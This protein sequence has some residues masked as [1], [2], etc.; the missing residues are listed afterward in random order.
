VLGKRVALRFDPAPFR[1]SSS[2]GS[3]PAQKPVTRLA[4]SIFA[5]GDG[6]SLLHQRSNLS[7]SY[8]NLLIIYLNITWSVAELVYSFAF[9]LEILSSIP[10]GGEANLFVHF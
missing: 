2:P 7:W 4:V 9:D 6:C 3:Q 8:Q 10:G 5:V 1:T